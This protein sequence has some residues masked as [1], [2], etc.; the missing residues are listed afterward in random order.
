MGQGS[1]LGM[2]QDTALPHTQLQVASF[3]S[4][5]EPWSVTRSTAVCAQGPARSCFAWKALPAPRVHVGP[6]V[7]FGTKQVKAH[8]LSEWLVTAVAT[9]I[10]VLHRKL[11]RWQWRNSEWLN[12]CL[13]SEQNLLRVA[14]DLK[15]HL[16]Q[17]HSLCN[18]PGP[19]VSNGHRMRVLEYWLLDSKFS[20]FTGLS[21][22]HKLACN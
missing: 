3:R 2:S 14:R 19:T 1:P 6:Q 10:W 11:T 15:G 17:L 21:V 20:F 16:V 12:S 7:H 13:T 4:G 8:S 18:D 22:I 5:A 9:G